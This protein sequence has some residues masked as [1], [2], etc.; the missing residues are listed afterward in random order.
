MTSNFILAPEGLQLRD[1]DVW[2]PIYDAKTYGTI[3]EAR[4]VRVRRIGNQGE[5]WE[6]EFEE[7]P[8]VTGL[9]L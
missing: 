7:A 2:G 1:V 3:M 4:V 5:T 8:G 6:I 9:V